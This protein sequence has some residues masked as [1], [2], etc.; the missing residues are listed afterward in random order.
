MPIKPQPPITTRAQQFIELAPDVMVEDDQGITGARNFDVLADS[1][2][3]ARQKLKTSGVFIDAPWV[4]VRGENPND[5]IKCTAIEIDASPEAPLGGVGRYIC[6]AVYGDTDSGGG[7]GGNRE[8]TPDGSPVYL[9]GGSMVSEPVDIDA[10]GRPITNTVDEPFDPPLT[11]L[12]PH[13]LLTV[14]WVINST[15]IKGV[16]KSMRAYRGALNSST[17]LGAPAKSVLC[18]GIEPI[19]DGEFIRATGRFEFRPD[20]NPSNLGGAVYTRSGPDWSQ[21][22]GPFSGWAVLVGNRGRRE[23]IGTGTDPND[24]KKTIRLYRPAPDE[25]GEPV[26]DPVDLDENGRVLKD[27]GTPIIL[28]FDLIGFS[29]NFNALGI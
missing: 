22:T 9:M 2:L 13:E 29:I 1:Q 18:H 14:K 11:A 28:A 19:L 24:S 16:I 8:A 10:K 17:W 27:G 7:G 25:K 20:Y 21:V 3:D 23:L 15:N 5:N 26:T 6:R 4:T 12:V